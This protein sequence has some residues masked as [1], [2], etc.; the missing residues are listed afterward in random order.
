[1]ESRSGILH[2]RVD[3]FVSKKYVVHLLEKYLFMAINANA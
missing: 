2:F 1:M 3:V